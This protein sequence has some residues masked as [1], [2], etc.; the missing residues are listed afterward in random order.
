MSRPDPE[1]SRSRA[2]AIEVVGASVAYDADLVLDQIDLRVAAG[3]MV[4]LLG[5]S[6]C[7]KTT[8][9]RAI[10]GLEPVT[11]GT[12]RVGG[13][14]VSGAGTHVAPE[15]RRVGMVFQDWALFPHLTVRKNVAYGLHRMAGADERV[16][17]VM[18][19]V[20]LTGF[21]DRLPYTLSGG[22]QQRVALARAL[23][24]R[25]SVLLLDE[26]FSNLD[27]S[28]RVE[29]RTD[30]HRLLSD[31]DVTSVFVTHDQDEA[32]VL[33]DDVAVMQ[34]GRIVQMGSPSELYAQPST[35][36]VATFVG[37]AN[38]LTA[39]VTNGLAATSVGSV[40]VDLVGEGTG[41]S[42]YDAEVLVRPEDLDVQPDGVGEVRLIEYYGHDTTYEIEI[43]GELVRARLASA[44]RFQR[45]D[46]VTV[47][48]RG[49][50]TVA[51][52]QGSQHRRR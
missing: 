47:R 41:T 31:L 42:R 43:G 46:R 1:P 37:E 21:D 39:A 10:A 51:F 15:R 11:A 28:L 30:V 3:S 45:G 12:I 17:E 40:R 50:S 49:S 22:Q 27:T 4:A 9:L 24:P 35:P 25:P 13:E 23:A 29:I 8:L 5:P 32:F 2:A 18:A 34:A 38:L 48:Y 26:P 36:W 44:P 7:G 6:G 52:P 19:M 16:D 20:G 33:G 14:V